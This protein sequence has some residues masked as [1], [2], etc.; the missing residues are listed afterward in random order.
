MNIW[1]RKMFK[2]IVTDDLIFILKKIQL[3]YSNNLKNINLLNH[4]SRLFK[5]ECRNPEVLIRRYIESETSEKV[6]HDLKTYQYFYGEDVG[7]QLFNNYSKNLSKAQ[8]HS[9]KTT[10]RK[11]SFDHFFVDYWIKKGY[12]EKE[13]QLRI[14]QIKNNRRNGIK[15]SNAFKRD[16]RTATQ[17]G[18]WIK[19]GYSEEDAKIKLKKRQT[20]FSK[21]ICIE[22]LGKENGTKRWKYR[23]M[24]WQSTL[25]D[26]TDEEKR[27][28]NRRKIPVGRSAI[29]ISKAEFELAEKLNCKQQLILEIE[30]THFAYDLYKNNKIIEYNGDYWHCNPR[31]YKKD[32]YNKQVKLNA[33]FIWLKDQVKIKHAKENGYEV[34]VVWEMDYKQNPKKIIEECQ[35]FLNG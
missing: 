31:K 1:E 19:K 13:A 5:L 6:K 11:A 18:Y 24:K 22:K 34:K 25:D 23:Q 32:Y 2:D 17:I 16:D 33:E 30:N 15:N 20:T 10:N 4:I 35:E 7:I 9:Y 12:S 3:K 28:I 21:N 26:K 14:E 27:D 8:K 29:T